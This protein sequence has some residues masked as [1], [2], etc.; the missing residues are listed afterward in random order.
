MTAAAA[1]AN[2][3]EEEET[4]SYPQE[5][6]NDVHQSRATSVNESLWALLPTTAKVLA[7]L[8]PS[9]SSFPSTTAKVLAA[10]DPSYSSFPSTTACKNRCLAR[11]LP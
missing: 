3:K 6:A 7:A 8:D 10:L 9:Y 5:T 1:A 11:H 2:E 4:D